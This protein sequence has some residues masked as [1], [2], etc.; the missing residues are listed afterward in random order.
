MAERKQG[1]LTG[2][3]GSLTPSASE[4][5]QEFVPAETR[6]I[7]DPRAARRGVDDG[8]TPASDAEPPSGAG[9]IL[10]GDELRNPEDEHL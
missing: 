6:E 10:G 8:A 7:N 9:S 5:E 1:G 2:A 3:I 4:P